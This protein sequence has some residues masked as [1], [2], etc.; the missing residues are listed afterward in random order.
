MF[1]RHRNLRGTSREALLLK[2][3]AL[4]RRTPARLSFTVLSHLIFI[5][6]FLKDL[7]TI[8]FD[9]KD[10]NNPGTLR[11]GGGDGNGWGWNP[12]GHIDEIDYTENDP[13]V[14]ITKTGKLRGYWMQVVGGRKIRAFEGI[15]YAGAF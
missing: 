3:I 7:I 13:L 9:E 10:K 6:I 11:I 1:K 4:L 5:L 8:G 12:Q 15:P 14:A 2:E